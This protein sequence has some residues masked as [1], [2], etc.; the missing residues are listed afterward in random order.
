[1]ATTM[2]RAMQDKT[3]GTSETIEKEPTEEGVEEGTG[4]EAVTKII[5]RGPIEK[6]RRSRLVGEIGIITVGATI[7]R[8]QSLDRKIPTT[9]APATTRAGATTTTTTATTTITATTITTTTEG[10]TTTILIKIETT[11][12][13]ENK[14]KIYSIPLIFTIKQSPQSL[15]KSRLIQVNPKSLFQLRRGA[16]LGLRLVFTF[17]NAS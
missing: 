11:I 14:L 17:R 1:M 10:T 3:T 12:L 8:R 13:I 7:G 9:T 4:D 2:P 16:K 15:K 5:E 6:G